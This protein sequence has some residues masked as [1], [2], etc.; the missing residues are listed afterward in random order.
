MVCK[1]GSISAMRALPGVSIYA[2]LVAKTLSFY[3]FAL[4]IKQPLGLSAIAG[5]AAS[6]LH[7]QYTLLALA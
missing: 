3:L 4:R 1:A 6:S 2:Q 7:D 5:T